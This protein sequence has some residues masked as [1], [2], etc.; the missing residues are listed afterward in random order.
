MS[1]QSEEMRKQIKFLRDLCRK[2]KNVEDLENY[3]VQLNR[4]GDEAKDIWHKIGD[5]RKWQNT[6]MEAGWS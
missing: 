5:L 3:A 1:T 4:L 6:S 2:C